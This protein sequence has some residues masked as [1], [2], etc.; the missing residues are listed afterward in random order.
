ME[1]FTSLRQ[2]PELSWHS[3]DQ[4]FQI[5]IV[6]VCFGSQTRDIFIFESQTILTAFFLNDYDP[7]SASPLVHIVH[8]L[9]SDG[10]IPLTLI[11]VTR[12]TYVGSIQGRKMLKRMFMSRKKN[13]T[14]RR[15]RGEGAAMSS[16]EWTSS[17]L[18]ICLGCLGGKFRPSECF[19]PFQGFEVTSIRLD[20]SRCSSTL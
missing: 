11:H 18:G 6:T 10:E 2:H 17:V 3:D 8:F 20:P 9:A 7:R 5:E 15:H 14:R 4:H 13:A 16:V 12:A 19:T 1:T